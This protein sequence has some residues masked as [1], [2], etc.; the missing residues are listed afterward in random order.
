MNFISYFKEEFMH[1]TPVNLQTKV[2]LG[3]KFS[4][5]IYVKIC[6]ITK[7]RRTIR[8]ILWGHESGDM[9][10]SFHRVTC[11]FWLKSLG[12]KILSSKNVASFSCF[13]FVRHEKSISESQFLCIAFE[14]CPHYSIEMNR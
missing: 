11:S 6:M 9:M 8:V 1:F 3:S 13:E 7:N 5:I 10:D 2:L 4:S 12:A 14:T